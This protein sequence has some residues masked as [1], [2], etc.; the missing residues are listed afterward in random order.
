MTRTDTVSFGSM[1]SLPRKEIGQPSSV[2]TSSRF[3]CSGA[4]LEA[5][6]DSVS[7][8]SGKYKEESKGLSC[9]FQ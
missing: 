2:T 7:V 4:P 3:P 8:S 5:S 9:S 6:A 1:V